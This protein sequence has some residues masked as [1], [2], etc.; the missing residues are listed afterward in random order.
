MPSNCE[1]RS[2]ITAAYTGHHPAAGLLVHNVDHPRESYAEAERAQVTRSASSGCCSSGSQ[3]NGR[4]TRASSRMTGTTTAF[5]NCL[6]AR[7]SDTGILNVSGSP[8]S[9][10]HSRGVRRR[11]F[12][13]PPWYTRISEP[14]LK[15]LAERVRETS[16]GFTKPKPKP[17]P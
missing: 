3:T 9:L 1:F 13:R 4:M 10:A 5:P 2:R 8:I 12:F 15:Y 16:S 7:V 6:Y 11:G 17:L 14:S